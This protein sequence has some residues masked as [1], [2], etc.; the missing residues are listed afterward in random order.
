VDEAEFAGFQETVL[1][2]KDELLD[3]M[4]RYNAVRHDPTVSEK[5]KEKL[6]EELFEGDHVWPHI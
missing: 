3:K 5:K 1:K 6:R 2:M 4:K